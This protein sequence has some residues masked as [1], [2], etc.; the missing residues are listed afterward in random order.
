VSQ[1]FY[2]K[3]QHFHFELYHLPNRQGALYIDFFIFFVMMFVSKQTKQS[4]LILAEESPNT[5]P[6]A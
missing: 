5:Q 1:E 3:V 6:R 2:S 4:L